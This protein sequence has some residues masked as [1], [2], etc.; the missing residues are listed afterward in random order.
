MSI[1]DIAVS[2][3]IRK[4]LLRA[5]KDEAVLFQ[6]DD[7]AVVVD[8][9]RYED[10]KADTG[11]EPLEDLLGEVELDTGAEFFVFE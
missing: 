11:T 10:L 9:A 3:N 7:G 1:Q 8:V 6:D 2:H 4:K 5:V